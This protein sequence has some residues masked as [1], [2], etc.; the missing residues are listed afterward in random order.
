ML[1]DNNKKKS[2]DKT[3]IKFNGYSATDPLL[4]YGLLLSTLVS[5]LQ[6]PIFERVPCEFQ[7]RQD[8]SVFKENKLIICM[9]NIFIVLLQRTSVE[10]IYGKAILVNSN[11][12]LKGTNPL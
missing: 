3:R 5:E 9:V 8:H 7:Q 10:Q 1:E 6:H 11:Y 2:E 4:L 12:F